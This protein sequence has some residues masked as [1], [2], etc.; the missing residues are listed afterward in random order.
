LESTLAAAMREARVL[1]SAEPSGWR[2]GAI[3]RAFFQHPLSGLGTKDD[4]G[5]DVGDFPMGGDASTPMLATPRLLDARITHGASVRLIM[6]VGDWDRSL[7]INTPGQSGDPASKF[8]RNLA[9]LW[10]AGKYV[11]L[12]FSS[13]AIADATD[14]V[15]D[16]V[17][18]GRATG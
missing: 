3:H 15:I 13:S 8:Y 1:V 18:A 9:P 17:P 5:F 12:L 2:W 10:A 11:P 7:C 16:L 14:A 4:Q 6:N